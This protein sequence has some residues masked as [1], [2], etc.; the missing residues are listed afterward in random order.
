MGRIQSTSCRLLGQCTDQTHVGLPSRAPSTLLETRVRKEVALT[1]TAHHQATAHLLHDF[2]Q[3]VPQEHLCFGL[4]RSSRGANRL[5]AVVTEVILPK[6]DEILLHGNASFEGRYL[7]RATREA[8]RQDAGLVMMHS[9]PGSGWQDLSQ[10]DVA[11]ERDVVAYQA[12]GTGK[13]FL[14]MTVGTDGYWSAR[15]WS[16]QSGGMRLQW[17]SKVRVARQRRY[18]IDWHP[19]SMRPYNPNPMLRRT[20]D[21]WGIAVQARIGHLRIGIVG[22]GSVGAIAAEALARIGISEIVLID[23]DRI[24]LHNLD[25]FLFGTRRCIGRLKVDVVKSHIAAHST[26]ESVRIRA[27]PHGIEYEMAY[28]EALDCDLLLS[29]VDRPVPRD[30]LNYIAIASGIPVIDAGVAVD[31]DPMNR[32]FESARWRSHLVIPGSACLRCTGQYSSSDVVAE[33]DGSLDSP[34]YIMNLPEELRPQNQNV[35]PFSL[36]CA[37][38]QVNLMVRYLLAQQWWP[39]IQRQEYRFVA[40]EAKRT[41]ARCQEHCVFRERIG[42]GSEEMPMYMKAT[43]KQRRGMWLF[44]K[45]KLRVGNLLMRR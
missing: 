25:R 3:G 17:C 11:A 10:T 34:S 22:V 32:T 38:M 31:V 8:R 36:G 30:V 39:P 21:T 33:L 7:T 18:Q 44:Q 40:G 2:L 43:P 41:T 4:W 24:E 45:M 9:H 28:R 37:S 1:A 20:V 16:W 14:G 27:I 23:P 19:S 29:C 15:F 26:S 42:L 5:T 12:Q 6:P 13:P 35:F